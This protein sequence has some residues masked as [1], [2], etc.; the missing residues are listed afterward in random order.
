ML[1]GCRFSRDKQQELNHRVCSIVKKLP[2]HVQ[3]TCRVQP[4]IEWSLRA[5]ASMRAV[6]LFLPARA[7]IKFVLR[8]ASTLKKQMASSEHFV[9]ILGEIKISLSMKRKGLRK[10]IC[11]GS[12]GFEP[13]TG[14]TL[15]VLK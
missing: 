4:M 1:H 14:P 8:A 9:N 7:V 6:R 3:G 13:R 12:R 2:G 10:V 11:A 15:R 5:L